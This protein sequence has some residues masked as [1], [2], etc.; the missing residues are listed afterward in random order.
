M[1]YQDKP[2]VNDIMELIHSGLTIDEAI[3]ELMHYG[4]PR[5]SGRYPWGSGK[6][7]YQ[8]SGDFL[9]RVEQLTKQGLSEQEIAKSIGL[10]TTQ[11]RIQKSMAKD[12]RRTLEVETAKGLREKGYS[13]NEIAKQMG[14]KNDSSVR[15]LLNE[16]SESRMKQAKETSE[17]LRKQVESKGMIDIGAGVEREL[18]ISK[19]KLNE[20]VYML[21]MEGYQVFK[22]GVKQASGSGNQTNLKVLAKPDAEY[23][24][25]YDYKNVKTITEYKSHDDGKTFD[26]F[27]YPASMSSDRIKIR[28]AEDGGTERDGLIEL[29][30][31][32]KDLSLGDAH[33]A[34]VRILVDGTHY[35]K[36]MAVYAD[37]LP[38]GVDIRFNTNKTKDK[39][40]HEV[41]KEIKKDNPDNPFG[42]LIK[43]GGQSYYIDDDGKRKLSVINK[44]SEEGDWNKWG[45]NLP[46]QFLSKQNLQLV[47]RQL[48]L[49]KADKQA[50][51]DEIMSLSNPT[52]KKALLK[53]FADGCDSAAEHLQAAALPRQK[54]HVILPVPGLK[55]NE[56]YA[57]NYND[58]EQVALIRYPH[59]GLF[60]I[61]I[62][63]V[64]NKHADSQKLIGKNPL[65][66]VC[67]NSKV[68]ERL[69]GADFDGDTVQVIPTNA[70]TRISSKPPLKE[71]EGF[72]PKMQYAERPGMKYMKDPKTGKD[73]TQIEMGKISN[74][75]T[76]MTLFGAS[77][78]EIARAVKHSMVVIDAGKH[79]LD[80]KQSEA[81][82]NIAALKKKYQGYIDPETGRYRTGA[83]TIVS[84]A[85]AEQSVLKRQGSPKIDPKT[86]KQTWDL[87]DD[88]TYERVK[89]NSKGEVIID[90]ATGKP[91]METITKTQKSTRMAETD[92]AFS[93]VS[94]TRNPK[95][96]A[97]AEYANSMKA[98]ANQARKVMI[99]T[100]DIPY[101]PEAKKKYDTEVKRLDAALNVALKN[102]PRERQAQV[103]ANATLQAVT[104][105]NPNMSNKD[106]KKVAQ[107]A[108][109]KARR[110]LGAKKETIKISDR[111]WEAIQAGAI[112]PNKLKQILNNSD[113]DVVKKMAMPKN[114]KTLSDAK[115]A[116]IAT[117]KASGYT[118]AQIAKKLGVSTS[119]II[120]YLNE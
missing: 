119:T 43:A 33:Y 80:Y 108:L 104:Q 105:D 62:L 65:D 71:L 97:Y 25:M 73:N 29:R 103:M 54:Y 117:L 11:L 41:M 50:E 9:S 6:D 92:D 100:P 48:G 93:L 3:D 36:G 51:F 4:M 113:M 13:L 23:K 20:A 60:E 88:L 110:E 68:A 76:D 107:Q 115:I 89:K 10:T 67:I 66:A 30:R 42:A 61:P 5:R 75:I 34:Q 56:I 26:T 16:S 79:K 40:K 37:D 46:S 114:S 96:I 53:D 86:G 81:D 49:A 94:K 15:S 39:S 45:D 74:L 118:N 58:G 78:A 17:F 8:H 59:G 57:P 106:K 52:V 82:N 84:R 12:E 2:N 83:G 90:K 63:T 95:E 44:K 27:Q 91:K 85:S 18:G 64:N 22:G 14:Y 19:E 112:S 98:Y 116:H 31:G 120:K 87:A 38:D 111:E 102:A 1:A 35:L 69:S 28:Y 77:D 101:S 7:P 72:D 109:D 32:V 55:D 70:K 21:E 47:K 24:D 99:N